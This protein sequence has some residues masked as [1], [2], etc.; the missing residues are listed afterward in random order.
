MP[1]RPKSSETA[2]AR[3]TLI[4]QSDPT[5]TLSHVGQLQVQIPVTRF[6]GPKFNISSSAESGDENHFHPS[7]S[8]TGLSSLP[9]PYPFSAAIPDPDSEIVGTIRKDEVNT[10]TF[11][12]EEMWEMWQKM[13][14]DSDRDATQSNHAS[15]LPR[16]K[17]NRLLHLPRNMRERRLAGK[18]DHDEDMKVDSEDLES[19]ADGRFSKSD[20]AS[21]VASNVACDVASKLDLV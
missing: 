11:T 20:V 14:L 1:T 3:P 7:S 10:E 8:T 9:T 16:L 13:Y 12:D 2:L 6:G 5:R 19:D 18:W 15:V 4:S 21:N 17:W